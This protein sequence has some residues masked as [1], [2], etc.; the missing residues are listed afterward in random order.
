MKRLQKTKIIATR[1]LIALFGVFFGLLLSAQWRSVPDR[2]TNP[3]APYA[4]LKETKEALYDEQDNLKREILTLQENV[5][6]LQKV[7]KE[8]VLTKDEIRDLNTKKARAGLTKLNGDGIIIMLDDGKE[9]SSDDSIIHAADIRDVLNLLWSSGAEGIS[10]NG[11]RVVINTAVD[12]IVNTILI[13][14]VRLSTPFQIEAV[15]N[16]DQMFDRVSNSLNLYDLHKRNSTEKI[17][18][19]I[20][21]HNDITLPLFDGSFNT[22]SELN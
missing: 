12:C 14:N 22:R 3:I 4:S 10:I 5:S 16:K 9:S 21:R 17:I 18:F 8:N 6:E 19:Q 20:R 2:V 7:S 11:Q 1:S 13:N 15:G